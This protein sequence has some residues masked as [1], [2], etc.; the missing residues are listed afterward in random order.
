MNNPK[1]IATK[2]SPIIGTPLLDTWLREHQMTGL[3]IPGE[4]WGMANTEC[5]KLE[6]F[7]AL[8]DVRKNLTSKHQEYGAE[9]RRV[10][11]AILDIWC[12]IFERIALA[13]MG[14]EIDK[15]EGGV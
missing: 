12:P 1:Q 10:Q 15:A 11:S 14:R 5:E 2:P 8:N 3:D 7:Q 13:K 4:C 6:I 9:Y